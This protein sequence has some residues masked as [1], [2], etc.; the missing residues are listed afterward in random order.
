MDENM[1]MMI[2]NLIVGAGS[3]RSYAFESIGLAKE[4][5]FEEARAALEN[6]ANDLSGVHATQTDLIQKEARGEHM[7]MGLIM[8]HAQ[9][10]I[11]TSMLAR[12][13]AAE[14]VELYERLAE[15]KSV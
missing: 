1:E 6:A 11:M 5:K 3:A 4:G 8:V 7:E 2:M 15:Q 12:E 14:I 9:D 10:H 13:L